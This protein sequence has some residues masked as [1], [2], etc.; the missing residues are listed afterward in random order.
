MS[1]M[2]IKYNLSREARFSKLE[3]SNIRIDIDIDVDRRII[4]PPADDF[5]ISILFVSTFETRKFAYKSRYRCDILS[6]FIFLPQFV[7][8]GTRHSDYKSLIKHNYDSLLTLPLSFVVEGA[9]MKKEE[10]EG[11]AATPTPPTAAPAMPGMDDEDEDDE[12]DAEEEEEEEEDDEEGG[13]A[14]E[15]VTTAVR[16]E[17]GGM[18]AGEGGGGGG[19]AGYWRQSR[20]S[21]PRMPPPE[22][23]EQPRPK[24]RQH[25]P[26]GARYNNLG[27]WRARRVTFYKNGDPY[28]P[29]VEFR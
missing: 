18:L 22:Q 12:E 6:H 26:T 5:I 8:F 14:V 17:I 23:S 19:M 28:F 10:Q 24:S 15:G 3:I 21:S 7:I 2:Y 13:I 29:G 27:Y 4:F 20:P 1:D 11:G 16:E 9:A 25:E